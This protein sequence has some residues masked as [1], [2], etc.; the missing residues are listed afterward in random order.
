MG[1][2]H[3]RRRQPRLLSHE[4]MSH[5]DDERGAPARCA[6]NTGTSSDALGHDELLDAGFMTPA[7]WGHSQPRRFTSNV[8]ENVDWIVVSSRQHH[9]TWIT[10]TSA[11]FTSIIGHCWVTPATSRHTVPLSIDW[12]IV[13]CRDEAY[14]TSTLWPSAA[15]GGYVT[16]VAQPMIGRRRM[17]KIQAV[18]QQ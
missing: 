14:D 10:R 15:T 8:G 5:A 4:I 13:S 1:S 12:V 18:S 6:T 2:I 16:R 3:R 17:D 11:S 7:R 9:H